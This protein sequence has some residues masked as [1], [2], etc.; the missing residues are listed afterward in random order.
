M[1]GPAILSM[2]LPRLRKHRKVGRKNARVGRWG[3]VLCHAVFWTGHGCYINLQ[4]LWLTAH[5]LYK[6]QPGASCSIMGRGRFPRL[7]L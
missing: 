4:E 6:N 3:G 5:N 7:H 2:P 1:D